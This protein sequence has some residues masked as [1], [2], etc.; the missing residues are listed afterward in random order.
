MMKHINNQT[1]RE[2]NIRIILN[3]IR[4]NGEVSRTDLAHQL[5]LTSPAVTNIVAA[6]IQDGLVL[7]TGR[8]DSALGR[9]PVLLSIN[10]AV[11]YLLGMVLTTEGI[12]VVISD[13][14]ANILHTVHRAIDPLAGSELI[15]ALMVDGAKQ[16]MAEV[17]AQTQQILACGIAAPGPLDVRSGML[18]NPPNFPSWRNVPIC[19]MIEDALGIPAVL[20]KET[21]AAAMAEYYFGLTEEYKTMFLML[22]WQDSI[23]GSILYNGNVLHGYA[24]GAG[25]IGHS[26]VDI[27]GPLCS[28]G[29]YGCLERVASGRALVQEAQAKLKSM[30]N[31]NLPLPCSVDDLTMEDIVRFANMGTPLFEEVMNHFAQMVAVAIGNVI[32]LLSPSLFIIGGSETFVDRRLVN[33]IADYVHSRSY[34][35]CVKDIRIECSRLGDSGCARGAVMLALDQFQT[36]LCSHSI[37][38]RAAAEV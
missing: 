19:K 3:T 17:G 30:R 29:Q 25:D 18:L 5:G 35:Q 27:N 34:P 33:K 28:C 11:C 14:S 13:F 26:L 36:S 12:T 24:D 38:R 32:S 10:P 7:E 8:S 21:N 20:D 22:I 31:M 1:M 2:N 15:I 16:C 23:G 37:L 4:K 9:K 6:L